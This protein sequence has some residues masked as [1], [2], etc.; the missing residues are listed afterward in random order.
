MVPFK[1]LVIDKL[2]WKGIAKIIHTTTL[3]NSYWG[4]CLRIIFYVVLYIGELSPLLPTR[5]N[6]IALFKFLLNS[7]RLFE[8]SN[9]IVSPPNV[10]G[11]ETNGDF[12]LAEDLFSFCF[13]F[14]ANNSYNIQTK[15][16]HHY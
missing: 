3:C 1:F 13:F 4:G 15:D 5:S 14:I 2:N 6:P 8:F 9:W 12:V 10:I 16:K 11:T 7:S